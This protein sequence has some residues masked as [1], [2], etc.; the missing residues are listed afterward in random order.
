MDQFI[1]INK[2][3][4][5]FSGYPT[6][7]FQIF[8]MGINQYRTFFFITTLYLRH[9]FRKEITTN[10]RIE[11]YRISSLSTCFIHKTS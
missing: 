2:R 3:Y 5:H 11:Q 8:P 6:G 9:T 7:R 4:I 10:Y 1:Q